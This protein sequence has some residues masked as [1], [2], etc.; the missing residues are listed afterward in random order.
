MVEN[1][2]GRG[3]IIFEEEPVQSPCVRNCC[4]DKSDI[5]MGCFRHLSEITA[6]QSMPNQSREDVLHLCKTRKQDY[7]INENSFNWLK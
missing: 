1:T 6:W 4:L 3:N 5:C 7:N 2:K